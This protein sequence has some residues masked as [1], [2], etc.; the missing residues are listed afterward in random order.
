MERENG[1]CWMSGG[2]EERKLLFSAYFGFCW[3]TNTSFTHSIPFSCASVFVIV[4]FQCFPIDNGGKSEKNI[5]SFHFFFFFFPKIKQHARTPSLRCQ[6]SCWVERTLLRSQR[7]RI[8]NIIEL[9]TFCASL[10]FDDESEPNFSA[11]QW[12]LN[13][14]NNSIF[15][16]LWQRINDVLETK[17]EEINFHTKEL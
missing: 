10:G 13:W 17:A 5:N 1:R 6:C 9:N 12:E 4:D 8:R 14:S 15:S 16:I 7:R 2:K 3:L 11:K